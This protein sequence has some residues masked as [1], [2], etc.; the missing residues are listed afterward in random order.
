MRKGKELTTA[1]VA[2]KSFLTFSIPLFI[3]LCVVP[4]P[5]GKPVMSWRDL[6]PDSQ[7]IRQAKLIL[8]G[9]LPQGE[10]KPMYKWQDK[11]GSWQISEEVPE[12]ARNPQRLD[13]PGT[14]S[15]L[16]PLSSSTKLVYKWQD[17]RGNWHFSEEVPEHAKSIAQ[18]MTISTDIN[19]VHL[20]IDKPG[21]FEQGINPAKI[22]PELQK[23]IQQ[24]DQLE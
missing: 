24:K 5:G 17:K 20:K 19:T 18:P 3:I 6:L 10:E 7:T 14:I 13:T 4:G 15:N 16:S 11:E 2:I 1:Q 9:L 23:N 12:Y 22:I 21:L 8:K